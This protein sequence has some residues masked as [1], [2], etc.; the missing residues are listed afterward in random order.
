MVS[1]FFFGAAITVSSGSCS[2][3]GKEAASDG[4]V[5]GWNLL[6]VF[7]NLNEIPITLRIASKS[8]F[9]SL[10]PKFRTNAY[11]EK[12]G[13]NWCVFLSLSECVCMRSEKEKRLESS[14]VVSDFYL[15]GQCNCNLSP[16]WEEIKVLF[17]LPFSVITSFFFLLS[18]FLLK[19]IKKSI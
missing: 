10:R 9:R 3:T 19:K 16:R 2:S 8:K 4:S 11:P 15:Q 17:G 1:L 13:R 5:F 6:P 18:S 14:Y 12:S 7:D